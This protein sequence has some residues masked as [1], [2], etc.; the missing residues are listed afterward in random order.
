MT[1][2]YSP[3]GKEF[4]TGSYDRSIRIF[5]AQEGHSR[6][7]YHTKRMQRIFAVHYSADNKYVLSG[8]DDTNIRMWKARANEKLNALL[9]REQLKQDY[10]DKL[11]E[12]YQFAPEVRKIAR[13]RI[14]PKQIEKARKMKHTIKEAKEEKVKRRRKHQQDGSVPFVP[15]KQKKIR[16]IEE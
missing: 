10:N 14:V 5:N 3:T 11:K 6:E 9:P 2:D 4:T 8:S 7:V 13:H 12:K 1:L 15:Q 16:R